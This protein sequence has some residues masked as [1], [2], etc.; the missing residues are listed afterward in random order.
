MAK[1]IKN[2]GKGKFLVKVFTPI[3]EVSNRKSRPVV[4]KIGADSVTISHRLQRSSKRVER[5]I[6]RRDF[7]LLSFNKDT[8]EL[9]FMLAPRMTEVFSVIGDV[10]IKN[11]FVIVTN[12][13]DGMTHYFPA[14]LCTIEAA[15][16]DEEPK[17][18]KKSKKE[19]KK[20]KKSKKSR[21]EEDED[22]DDSD[23]DDEDDEDEDSEDDED[24]DDSDSDEEDEDDEDSDDESEDEDDDDEDSDEEDDEDDDDSDSDDED[25]DDDDEPAP[26]K[27]KKG[28][29]R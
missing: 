3:C 20:A 24:D 12:A 7:Q 21:D 19:E 25:D 4:K 1:K 27:G 17:K 18:S 26:R 29:R 22:D 23:S 11:G 16:D 6:P 2:T 13:D 28:G 8:G 5:I 10:E 14:E 15:S 9:S